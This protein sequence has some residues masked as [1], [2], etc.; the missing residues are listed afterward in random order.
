MPL[1]TALLSN[2]KAPDL[3]NNLNPFED[4]ALIRSFLDGDA[5]SFAVLMDRHKCRIYTPIYLLVKDRCLAEDIFQD[6]FI[7]II[8][9]L[10]YG[11]YHEEER[12]ISWA[13]LVAHDLCLDHLRNQIKNTAGLVAEEGFLEWECQD[14][15]AI[16]PKQG[17]EQELLRALA[18]MP[19]SQRQVIILRH[20]AELDFKEIASVTNCSLDTVLGRMRYALLNLRR[21]MHAREINLCE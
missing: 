10:K 7:R 4:A 21:L 12:F 8:D 3:M 1:C 9:R 18:G 16:I 19:Q 6:V 20:F 2:R 14:E 13:V 11:K 17:Y 5:E 15:Q